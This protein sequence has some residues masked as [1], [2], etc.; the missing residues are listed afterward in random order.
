MLDKNYIENSIF[1]A[2]KNNPNIIHS[3]RRIQ[4]MNL[5]KLGFMKDFREEYSVHCALL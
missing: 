1:S 2:N 5:E 4:E 3:F